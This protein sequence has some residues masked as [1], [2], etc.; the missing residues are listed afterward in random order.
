MHRKGLLFAP[1][2]NV[3]ACILETV[4]PRDIKALGRAIPDFDEEAWHLERYN[5]VVMGNYLKFTQNVE[6]KKL[7]LDTGNKEL[8]EA[9]PRDRIW[10]VGF[11]W[12]RADEQRHKWGLNLL[13]KAL[14]DVRKRIK[15]EAANDTD[16]SNNLICR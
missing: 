3:T 1:H 7:L 8:V 15:A 6:L 11:G 4:N 14:M 12:K 5:I 10:G 2:H 9:S 13:G 16:E